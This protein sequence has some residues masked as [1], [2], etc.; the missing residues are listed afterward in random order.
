MNNDPKSG[1]L[2]ALE[3]AAR[4]THDIEE[5]ADLLRALPGVHSVEVRDYL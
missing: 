2:N 4:H 5:L 3:E 1:L